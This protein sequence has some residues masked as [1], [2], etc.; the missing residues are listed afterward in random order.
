MPKMKGQVIAHDIHRDGRQTENQSYP[1]APITMGTSPVRTRVVRKLFA[2]RCSVSVVAV[3]TFAHWCLPARKA[4][5]AAKPSP[6]P[7]KHVRS[8][9]RK[10]AGIARHQAFSCS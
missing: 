2:I 1:E 8:L 6:L 7:A 4:N 3:F 5:K 10:T 9:S